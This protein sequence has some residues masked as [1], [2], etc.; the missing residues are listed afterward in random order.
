MV[1]EALFG[2]SQKLKTTRMPIDKRMDKAQ[3]T[4]KWNIMQQ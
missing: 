2:N 1:I 4:H 3:Y